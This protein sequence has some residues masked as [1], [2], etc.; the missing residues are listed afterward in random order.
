MPIQEL[1]INPVAKCIPFPTIRGPS[2]LIFA[3]L[4]ERV[5]IVKYFIH[6]KNASLMV[7][8]D[9]FLPIHYASA[10]GNYE[11]LEDILSTE[12]GENQVNI[13]NNDFYTPLYFAVAH[14]HLKCVLLLLK[15]GALTNISKFTNLPQSLNTPL[16]L[17]AR[18]QDTTIA[19]ALLSKGASFSIVNSMNETPFDTCKTFNNQK[20][21]NYFIKV[22]QNPSLVRSFSDLCDI[23]LDNETTKLRNELE[24]LKKKFNELNSK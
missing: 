20:M 15:K 12:E 1:T 2:P 17:C 13:Q 14:S 9:G 21:M 6:E 22:S 18:L 11:I 23:Y 10:V 16:H 8:V 7:G 24:E 3:I 5:S 4:H 19:E